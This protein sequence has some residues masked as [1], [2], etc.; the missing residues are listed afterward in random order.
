M[1]KLLPISLLLNVALALALAW[2]LSSRRQPPVLAQAA[3][4]PSPAVLPVADPA[5]S[6]QSVFSAPVDPAEWESFFPIGPQ[7]YLGRTIP[8]QD[9]W[10]FLPP[11]DLPPFPG[12][13]PSLAPTLGFHPMIPSFIEGRTFITHSSAADILRTYRL[14]PEEEPAEDLEYRK[15][16]DERL[17]SKRI[18]KV[19]PLEDDVTFIRQLYLKQRHPPDRGLYSGGTRKVAPPKEK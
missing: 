7:M 13:A 4:P 14:L 1:R 8:A 18:R 5:P 15:E 17:K 6:E 10:H 3:G 12:D 2:A 19:S 9:N 16:L 11:L